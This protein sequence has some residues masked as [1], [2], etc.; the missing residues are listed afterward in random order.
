MHAGSCLQKDEFCHSSP[1]LKNQHGSSSF[2]YKGTKSRGYKKA[3]R[4]KGDRPLSHSD[5]PSLALSSLQQ[6]VCTCHFFKFPAL[7]HLCIDLYFYMLLT[8][9]DLKVVL[10]AKMVIDGDVCMFV[11]EVPTQYSSSF[12]M[13]TGNPTLLR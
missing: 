8:E 7:D 9:K 11:E 6:N 12:L 10:F 4:S 3:R 2:P 13:E 5:P 1:S